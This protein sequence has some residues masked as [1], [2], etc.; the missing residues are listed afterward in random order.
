[1]YKKIKI[2]FIIIII[3]GFFLLLDQFLKYQSTNVWTNKY[4]VLKYFGWQPFFNR[5]V[6][7]GFS[8]PNILTVVLTL[9]IILFILL[10]LKKEYENN[11][12]FFSWILILSGSISNLFDRIYYGYVIDYF[13]IITGIINIADV[14]IVS[15][16]LL[17]I[18]Q[19]LFLNQKSYP[20]QII[21]Y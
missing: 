5:G 1:M 16:L 20:K 19:S 11:V 4:S 6:A 21:E 9:I 3:S 13:T 7:F 8:L 15:G 14:L 17:Y 2:R 12:K 18:Y 10:I